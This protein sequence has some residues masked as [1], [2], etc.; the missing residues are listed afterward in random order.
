MK[1]R[2]LTKTTFALLLLLVTGTVVARAQELTQAERDRALH[3][4]ESTKANVLE[5]TRGL[6]MRCV[7]S[8]TPKATGASSWRRSPAPPLVKQESRRMSDNT[9]YV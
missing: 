3:Y 4:L 6:A 1:N 7:E 9:Y 5:A 2:S 8:S